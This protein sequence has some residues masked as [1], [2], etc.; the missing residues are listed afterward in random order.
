LSRRWVSFAQQPVEVGV[1][2]GFRSQNEELGNL[3]RV[4]AAD[5]FFELGEVGGGGL[6]EEQ[7]LGRGFDLPLPAVDRG[8]AGDDVD[9][10]GESLV[11]EGAGDVFGFVARAGGGHDQ[12]SFGGGYHSY[13]VR[14]TDCR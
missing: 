3:V 5:G 12:A 7:E 2:G 9:A 4:Q 11:D 13:R 6:D 1:A 8:E 14:V 10:C